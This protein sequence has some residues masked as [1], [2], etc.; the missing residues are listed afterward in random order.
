MFNTSRSI[1]CS[2]MA[3]AEFSN[4]TSHR[5]GH[6]CQSRHRPQIIRLEYKLNQ[7]TFNDDVIFG[8]L[9]LSYQENF[10]TFLIGLTHF[11]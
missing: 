3:D 8:G 11:F 7:F 5:N 10:T 4:S 9:D 6:H 2:T 1:S